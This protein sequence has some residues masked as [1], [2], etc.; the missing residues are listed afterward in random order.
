MVVCHGSYVRRA[1]CGLTAAIS[2]GLALTSWVRP[3]QAQAQAQDDAE[4]VDDITVGVI[5]FGRGDAIHQYFGHNALVIGGAGV[6]QPT[7]FN[8]GMFSF[9]PDLLP[10]FLRGRLKFWLGST[11]LR[12]TVARYAAANRDV[13]LLALNLTLPQR[14]AVL[15][16]LQRDARPENRSYLYDHYH[17]NC[18]TRVRDVLDG[19][20]H[21]QLRRAWADRAR[22]TLRQ[23]TMRHTQQDPLVEWL[24][25]LA[26]NGSVD[27]PQSLWS[28]AF[29]PLEL[30]ALLEYTTY[31]DENAARVPLVSQ[32]Q[33]LHHADRPPLPAQPAERWPETLGLGSLVAL[34]LLLWSERSRSKPRPFR[35]L[36]LLSAGLYGVAGGLMGS[37]LSYLALFS[38]H[39]VTH[40]NA[41]L[42]L[43]N[44][45]TLLAGLLSL[46]ELTFGSEATAALRLQ[47]VTDAVWFIL[48]ASS[49]TLVA[50]ELAP[51]GFEQD[52][53]LTAT[54]LVPINAGIAVARVR[55]PEHRRALHR[56]L[57]EP[58]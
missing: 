51:L 6:P 31:L 25:M 48:C 3:A 40:G 34:T 23:D 2:V 28:E 37:L 49:L 32:V 39:V 56:L 21:G 8:Y 52:V 58:T 26:L 55:L 38:D 33:T 36:L 43:L 41:N 5:T 19:A 53:S 50:L 9:G 17:D 45:L 27:R 16:K 1:L 44:P 13:R 10:Q 18:S 46:A 57:S 12:Q 11:E 24:M 42:F 22:F 35:A 4:A 15:A 29:L 14:R 20:L 54:L 7:V 47:R 30:E